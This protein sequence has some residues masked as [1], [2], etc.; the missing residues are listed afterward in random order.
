MG[1]IMV[2]FYS[3]FV[4]CNSSRN[5]TIQDVVGIK[6]NHIYIKNKKKRKN[7]D[8]QKILYFMD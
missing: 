7:S 3:D 1:I 2:N 4:N 8:E 6:L 5:A